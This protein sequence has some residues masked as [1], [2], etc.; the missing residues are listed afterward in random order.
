[1]NIKTV[2]P[3]KLRQT[4]TQKTG[5]FPTIKTTHGESRY[6]VSEQT[7]YIDIDNPFEDQI[8]HTVFHELAHY[9]YRSIGHQFH[10]EQDLNMGKSNF[11]FFPW[12]ERMCDNF[13]TGMMKV[14][15]CD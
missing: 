2:I 4:I 11:T 9:I 5:L 6:T 1:M 13:A 8:I 12:E 3:L 7:I 14:L 15:R 10:Q